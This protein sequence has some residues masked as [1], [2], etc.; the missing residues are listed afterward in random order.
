MESVL[1]YC[2]HKVKQIK[3][4]FFE[5]N[6]VAGGFQIVLRIMY[7]KNVK[8]AARSAPFWHFCGQSCATADDQLERASTGLGL[9]VV[10]GVVQVAWAST[11]HFSLLSSRILTGLFGSS[12]YKRSNV[13]IRLSM[14][15]HVEKLY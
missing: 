13:I 6:N 10:K 14:K 4:H 8:H 11:C 9:T 3:E 1:G 15:F 5:N 12:G 2:K 7:L